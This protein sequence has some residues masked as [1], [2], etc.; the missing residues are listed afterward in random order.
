MEQVGVR[1]LKQETAA[2]LRRV[3]A[4]EG[5]EITDHGHPVARLVPI[6]RNPVDQMI[7]EGRIRPATGDLEETM[8]RL[9]LP[10][11]R[12]K[13]RPLLSQILAEMRADE[14]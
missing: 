9:E 4:G 1:R 7:S 12:P 14:R 13:G 6:L 5:L 3:A 2:L 10:R 8:R 11:P